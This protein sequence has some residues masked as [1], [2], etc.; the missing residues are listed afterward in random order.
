MRAAAKRMIR[1]AS[2]YLVNSGDNIQVSAQNYGYSAGQL[3]P[4]IVG[5]LPAGWM[6]E[7]I[8]FMGYIRFERLK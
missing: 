1:D 3:L 2:K 4:F 8:G 5:L 6:A 7:S